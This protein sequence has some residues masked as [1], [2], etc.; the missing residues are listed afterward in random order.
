MKLNSSL[1]IQA[2]KNALA[3]ANLDANEIDL[4][5]SATV[6]PDFRL[7][8]NA[9]LIQAALATKQ[10]PA[11]DISAA[12]AGSIYG[13]SIA[14]S[15]IRSGTY[16]NIL[17]VTAEVMSTVID[18]TDRNTAVLFGD[19]ASAAVLSKTDDLACGFIDFD[20]YADGKSQDVISIPDGGSK[21]PLTDDNIHTRRDKVVMNGRETFKIAV[22]AVC[23][24]VEKIIA[25]NH[26]ALED[27][28]FVVPH[29]AN[30]RIIEAIAT[31]VNLP[32]DRFLINLDRYANTSAASLLLAYDE[33][34]ALAE[35]NLATS[36]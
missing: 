27:I 13:L 18:P 11:F 34:I 35:S 17:V 32:L 15:F 14:D 1:G 25:D 2:A 3:M 6:T 4:I 7:P 36:F 19:G 8:S 10:I 21:N 5:I 16:R 12:C 22:R 28:S 20:L 9:C 31:R 23:D 24:A 33:A 30:L 29:Q 26:I